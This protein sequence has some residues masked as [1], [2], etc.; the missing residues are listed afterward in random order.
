[1]FKY[2]LLISLLIFSLSLRAEQ[3]CDYD[4]M[5]NYVCYESGNTFG[6]AKGQTFGGAESKTFGVVHNPS[7]YIIDNKILARIYCTFYLKSF[8]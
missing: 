2:L 6:S 3:I 4:S 7:L 5:N 8:P 1:M